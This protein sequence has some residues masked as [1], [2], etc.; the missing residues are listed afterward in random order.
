MS[1]DDLTTSVLFLL[2]TEALSIM[3]TTKLKEAAELFNRLDNLLNQ[4]MTCNDTGYKHSR[5]LHYKHDSNFQVKLFDHDGSGLALS[6]V[7][8]RSRT[9][10]L[11]KG[12]G[13]FH[14]AGDHVFT[15]CLKCTSEWNENHDR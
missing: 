6:R 11:I 9:L 13:V 14:R 4:R 15:R 5:L 2:K 1:C 10:F 7:A 8:F 3:R 12:E